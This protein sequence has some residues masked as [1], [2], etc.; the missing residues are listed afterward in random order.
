V[1]RGRRGAGTKGCLFTLLLLTVFVYYAIGFGQVLWRYLKLKDEMFVAAGM[2]E[3]M[4]DDKI[5][6][7]LR[8]AVSDVGVP[9]DPNKFVIRRFSKQ[10]EISITYTEMVVLPFMHRPLELRTSVRRQL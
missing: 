10:I 8:K 6:G 3:E 7:Q 2:A 5:R 4:D 9:A 1:V